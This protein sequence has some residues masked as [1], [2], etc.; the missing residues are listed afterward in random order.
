MA[1]A[2]RGAAVTRVAGIESRGFI[3]GAR[4]AALLSVGFVPV[5]KPGKLPWRRARV[6]YQL[7][8]GSDALEMHEDA[9]SPHDRVL[10]VD[11]VLATGGTAQATAALLGQRGATVAGFAFLMELGFLDGRARLGAVPVHAVLTY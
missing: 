6:E 2:F 11:D 9:V 5:R 7:E 4:V 10:V 1:E 8:Y 3:F